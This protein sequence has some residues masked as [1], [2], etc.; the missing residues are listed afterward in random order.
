[1]SEKKCNQLQALYAADYA[2]E[3]AAKALVAAT[4][5]AL[6]IGT[7]VAVTLGRSR[8]RGRV[9]SSGGS[10]WYQPAMV[11]ITNNA[12]GKTRRFNACTDSIDLLVIEEPA[13]VDAVDPVGGSDN[14]LTT[15]V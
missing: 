7:Q 3:K 5:A 9:T 2:Y 13:S 14:G 8:I 11:I 1:M 4:E 12:T 15:R 6:P 10:W